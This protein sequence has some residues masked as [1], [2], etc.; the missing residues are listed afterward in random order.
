MISLTPAAFLRHLPVALLASFVKRLARL[1][2]S[3]PPAAIVMII[4]LTY[5]IL[6]KHPALMVMIHR[7]DESYEAFDGR[8]SVLPL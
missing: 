5:N 7:V 1:S 6:K 3:A 2:L 4:P 8:L